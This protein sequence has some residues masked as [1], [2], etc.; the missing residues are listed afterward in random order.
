LR[1]PGWRFVKLTR[2]FLDQALQIETQSF[3]F[4]WNRSLYMRVLACPGAL[5][6]AIIIKPDET[7]AKA[8]IAYL[9][10]RII[11]D[12]LHIMKIA[13]APEWR[14]QGAASALLRHGFGLAR[15]IGVKNVLLEVRPSNRLARRLYHGT[16]FQLIGKRANYY[17][18]TGEA[19]LL[20]RKNLEEDRCE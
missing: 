18:Q 5:N 13:V 3:K 19:A 15:K 11:I 7:K 6:R 20:Y 16:D 14:R 17:P 2:Q 1:L 12:E 10:S 8:L 9:C 4:P